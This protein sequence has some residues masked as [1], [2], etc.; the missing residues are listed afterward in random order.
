MLQPEKES[1][2]NDLNPNTEPIVLCREGT[3]RI[4]INVGGLTPREFRRV[5][6]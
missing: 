3:I 4:D 2:M 1:S 5:S 6:Q